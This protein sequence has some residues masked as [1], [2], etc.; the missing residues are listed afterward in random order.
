VRFFRRLLGRESDSPPPPSPSAASETVPL[1]SRSEVGWAT[2]VGRLRDHNEDTA[3]VVTAAQDGDSPFPSFEL[4]VLA[5]GMGGHRAGEMASSVAARRAA[6]HITRQSYL[7]S[8]L[9]RQGD[10]NRPA[11]TEVLINAVQSANRAVSEEA[12]G[13]GTTLTCALILGS[14]A[15]IAHVG[16]SRA[17]V[18]TEG[19]LEQVTQ[20]HSVADRLV[21]LGQITPAEAAVH[22][23]KNVL[24]RAVGQSTALEVDTHVRKIGPGDYL[25]LCSDGLW[26]LISE[27]DIVGLIRGA[28]SLQEACEDL[29]IAANEAGGRDNIT[30]MLWRAPRE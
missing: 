7:P 23:Q 20:D 10:A 1:P 26:G 16:D 27:T 19:G 15:Y 2:D 28:S 11:L 12:P 4:L 6:Y 21:D 22:P 30:A 18:L 3:L 8:L 13:S 9:D 25:L 14:Q 24:Y 17:Y 5:D 29:V